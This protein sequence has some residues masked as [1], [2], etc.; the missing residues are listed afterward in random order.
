MLVAMVALLRRRGAGQEPG[1]PAWFD[2]AVDALRSVDGLDEAT[3]ALWREAAHRE[4]KLGAQPVALEDAVRVRAVAIAGGLD[5]RIDPIAR[6]LSA[7]GA[8]PGG[9]GEHFSSATAPA[10]AFGVAGTV[11]AGEQPRVLVPIGNPGRVQVVGVAAYAG[12]F[13]VHG[14]YSGSTPHFLWA[15]DDLGQRHA[16][17]GGGAGGSHHAQSFIYTFLGA[18]PADITSLSLHF[19]DA[20]ALKVAFT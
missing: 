17:R 16:M 11:S 1:I 18:L 8:L 12:C 13:V 5:A 7:L 19:S 2:D 3:A 15:T 10:P 4:I 9:D 20:T 14:I 6:A